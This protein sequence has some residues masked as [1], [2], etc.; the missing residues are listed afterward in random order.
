MKFFIINIAIPKISRSLLAQLFTLKYEIPF[1][2][3]LFCFADEKS[4]KFLGFALCGKA[5]NFYGF[6]VQNKI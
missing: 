5:E 3:I 6:A 4:E 1:Q 2:T